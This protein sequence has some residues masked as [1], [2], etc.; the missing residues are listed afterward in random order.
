MLR[1]TGGVL[2][3]FAA[4][5]ASAAGDRAEPRSEPSGSVG[6]G[7]QRT[8]TLLATS[9]AQRRNRV[10]ILFYGQSITEQDWWKAVADDLRKRYPHAD[11]D[12]QNRAIGGFASQMLIMPAEHDLYPW[13]PD[14]VIFHVY[15][16]HDDYERII[17]SIRTRTTAEV[18]M[19]TDHVTRWP[20]PGADEKTDKALWWDH[21]MNDV[22]LPDIAR[23][24]GCRL[25]DIRGGWLAHLRAR[26]LEPAALLKD[27]VHLNDDG[28]K[29]MASLV[30]REL[31]HRPDL[32]ADPWKGMVR[33][34]T[35]GKEVRWERGV[36]RMSFEGN[37]VDVISGRRANDASSSCTVLVDGRPPS[38]FA[39]AY[40]ITRPEPGPW[41]PLF[42]ARVD[43]DK[44]LLIEDWTLKVTEVSDDGKRWRFTVT[45]SITG[46]DG[47]GDN[48]TEFVSKS[49]RVRISPKAHF[50][51]YG[52]TR[53][54]V[55]YE[56]R[57]KVLPL[58]ADTFDL[59]VVTDPSREYCTTLIQGIANGK[60]V[61]E[62]RT[63]DGRPAPI[64]AVRI[65]K[66]PY[67]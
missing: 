47:A 55:G 41:S 64:Q 36:L 46:P 6:V 65:H 9:T 11:L 62:I 60:H 57:W 2:V 51:G 50:T 31:V 37:R 58:H 16:A 45:G 33:T 39:D 67:R 17:R 42:I 35:V 59:P 13:Y 18:L 14:L 15:G 12:I 34:F 5:L 21:M 8:M 23:R 66:P 3:L 61:L 30:S 19:Q 48:L 38:S 53:P 7:I 26:G 54:P 22:Y 63:A 40:A 1:C 29:L 24:Y 56:C 4:S 52:T 43:H 25:A 49:G 28:C 32:P 10:R 44:P 27:G 20:D